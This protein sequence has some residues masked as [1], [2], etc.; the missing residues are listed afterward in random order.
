MSKSASLVSNSSTEI[1]KESKIF[2]INQ[3]IG[4]YNNGLYMLSV[5]YRVIKKAGG[6]VDQLK[7]F[8]DE[9]TKTQ[10]CIDELLNVLAEET[11]DDH[12]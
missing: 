12:H 2:L 5:R 8:E 9:M 1:S 7:T 3:L 11:G 4:E 6:S 10:M